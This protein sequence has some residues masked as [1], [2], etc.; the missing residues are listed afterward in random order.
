MDATT[1]R[2]RTKPGRVADGHVTGLYLQVTAPATEGDPPGRS[3]IFRFSSPT[4]RT[5]AGAGK[6][7]EMGIGSFRTFTLAEA[8]R[9]AHENRQLLARGIDPLDHRQQERE[10]AILAARTA[11]TFEDVA[12]DA[13]SNAKAA[14]RNVKHAAQWI[15]TL[16]TYAFPTLAK[17]QVSTITQDHVV[18]VLKPIWITKP[19][20]ATRVRQRIEATMALAM[21]LKLH[22]GPNPAS[23]EAVEPLL[24]KRKNTKKKQPS[25]D[26]RQMPAFIA[27]LAAQPGAGAR[28]LELTILTAARTTEATDA[29]WSEFDLDAGEWIVP[30][31]RMK[32]EREHRVALSPAAVALLRT[33]EAQRAGAFVFPGAKPRTPISEA[34]MSSV[35]HRMRKAGAVLNDRDGRPAVVHGFRAS[36]S[37]WAN[38][39]TN[40]AHDLIEFA[41]AHAVSDKVR[42]AYLRDDMLEKRRG[43]MADWATHCAGGAA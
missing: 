9:I 35:L 26:Y 5:T 39:A 16:T 22:P 29:D 17:R 34:A 18:Q 14:F 10:R 13:W 28:C 40:H 33:L 2:C 11:R 23:R 42:S 6:Q 24:P 43:L 7:R 30:A 27:A 12:N 4:H 3:W 20:T 37:T 25:L 1:A 15:A 41:L 32:A 36:F 38:A 19:E 8:R 31:G 21:S